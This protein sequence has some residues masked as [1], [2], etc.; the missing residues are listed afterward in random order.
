MT[1]CPKCGSAALD[2]READ[3]RKLFIC[4]VCGAFAY[5]RRTTTG[6]YEMILDEIAEGVAVRGHHE[7]ET[8][9]LVNT[10][11]RAKPDLGSLAQMKVWAA[12]HLIRLD[13]CGD[14]TLFERDGVALGRLMRRR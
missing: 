7:K 10:A 12:K 8:V 11:F 3:R 1:K 4:T 6:P 5:E 2:V 14:T 13:Q 9:L